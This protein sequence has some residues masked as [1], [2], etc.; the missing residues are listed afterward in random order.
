MCSFT[1]PASDL[2]STAAACWLH[3]KHI[4]SNNEWNT[5]RLESEQMFILWQQKILYPY[6]FNLLDLL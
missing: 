4:R 1:K 3:I 2:N 5:E 6:V